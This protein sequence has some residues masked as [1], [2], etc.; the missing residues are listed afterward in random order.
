MGR[1]SHL[2]IFLQASHPSLILRN[3]CH[4]SARWRA[5][6]YPRSSDATPG[7]RAHFTLGKLGLGVRQSAEVTP[8]WA[9]RGW[10]SAAA[11]PGPALCT[12][13]D[14]GGGVDG[15]AAGEWTTLRA[16]LPLCCG[17]APRRP[18]GP[19]A[20]RFPFL[21]VVC[22]QQVALACHFVRSPA[23]VAGPWQLF[24]QCTKDER[25]LLPGASVA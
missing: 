5:A 12:G 4:V 7:P 8:L 23:S 1:R 17:G 25:C 11:P 19:D 18:G 9:A 10:Q 20:I 24:S 14:D 6:R 16:L 13:S 22:L 3:G 15:P 21:L 2:R